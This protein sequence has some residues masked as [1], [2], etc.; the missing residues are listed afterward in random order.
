MQCTPY[1][2]SFQLQVYRN[3]KI[4]TLYADLEDSLGTFDSTK[5]VYYRIL[6]L[7]IASPQ[8]VLN[9][10]ELLEEKNYFEESFKVGG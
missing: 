2:S 7:R 6:D 8:I 1:N 3:L 9:F 4:W 5:K 10:A